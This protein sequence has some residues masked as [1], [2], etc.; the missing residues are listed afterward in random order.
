MKA[1][2]ESTHSD[3]SPG[4]ARRVDSAARLPHHCTADRS[5]GLLDLGSVPRGSNPMRQGLGAV[6]LGFGRWMQRPL[7]R[8]QARGRETVRVS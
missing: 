1:L 5:H 4:V 6:L 7:G 8:L 3:T 2:A